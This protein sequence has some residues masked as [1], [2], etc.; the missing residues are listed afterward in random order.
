MS[1]DPACAY[2]GRRRSE[3]P[4]QHPRY[5]MCWPCWIEAHGR[6]AAHTPAWKIAAWLRGRA[7]EWV[8]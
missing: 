5:A 3:A 4:W 6:V 2:C 7:I 1:Y 8:G